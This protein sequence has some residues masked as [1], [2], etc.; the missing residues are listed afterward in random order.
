MEKK[1]LEFSDDL[2]L[3]DI[4]KRLLNA[5]NE[6]WF[7]GI[8]NGGEDY[9]YSSTT[10]VNIQSVFNEKNE[11]LKCKEKVF[12]TENTTYNI[13][14]DHFDGLFVILDDDSMD[15][16]HAIGILNCIVGILNNI[17]TDGILKGLDNGS[18]TI[19]DLEAE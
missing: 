1:K 3:P 17:I 12:C 16:N 14:K 5:M 9:K 10:L 18:I 8:L 15:I 11:S 19:E 4:E 13:Y 7:L 6:C 2:N